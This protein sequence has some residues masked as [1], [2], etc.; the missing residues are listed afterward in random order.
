MK[1]QE[2][3]G[4][5][6]LHFGNASLILTLFQSRVATLELDAESKEEVLPLGTKILIG[7]VREAIT[8]Y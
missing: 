7:E 5:P 1:F 4:L 8:F 2:S 3:W 6:S